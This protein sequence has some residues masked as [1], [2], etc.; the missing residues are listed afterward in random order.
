MPPQPLKSVV[1]E[2]S[3]NFSAPSFESAP[4]VAK[5]VAA[6]LAAWSLVE[7][8][9]G[10]LFL[11]LIGARREVGADLWSSW[12]SATAKD[13]ALAS[14]AHSSLSSDDKR[15][16]D[17]VLRHAKANYA[18]RNK[19]AHWIWGT[20]SVPGV[21][22]L[23]NPKHMWRGFGKGADSQL[24]EHA[25]VSPDDVFAYTSQGL[26]R[27]RMEFEHLADMLTKLIMISDPDDVHP[28]DVGLVERLRSELTSD[29][30]L[31]AYLTRPSPQPSP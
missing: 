26:D 7:L 18:V 11:I 21:M 12:S 28:E 14:V 6:C 10:Q 25:T 30:R 3:C 24:P 1:R 17:A 2:A 13:S 9:L 23:V 20:T 5:G 31:A 15:L 16:F 22:A 29:V 4:D 27:D 8:R 19:L